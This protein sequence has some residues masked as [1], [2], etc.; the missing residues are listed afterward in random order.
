MESNYWTSKFLKAVPGQKEMGVGS[1]GKTHTRGD[2]C[3]SNRN[4]SQDSSLFRGMS[5]SSTKKKKN[6]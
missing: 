5:T 6:C 2:N 1:N 3:F 4:A